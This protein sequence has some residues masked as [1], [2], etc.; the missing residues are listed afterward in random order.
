MIIQ[1]NDTECY[2]HHKNINICTPWQDLLTCVK[3]QTTAD[4]QF[5]EF[6]IMCNLFYESHLSFCVEKEPKSTPV[7]C[8]T[9]QGIH[10][11]IYQD[12]I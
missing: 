11:S 2:Q 5:T 1:M 9:V 7:V 6:V 8:G 10:L 3:P 4:H 12:T